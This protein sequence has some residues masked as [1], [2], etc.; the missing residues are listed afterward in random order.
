MNIKIFEE[1]CAVVGKD[2]VRINEPM[3]CHT[4]FRCGGNAKYFVLPTKENEIMDIISIANRENIQY[5]IV[6]NGSNL[7][8]SDEGY[9]GIVIT[10]SRNY[11]GI[12]IDGETVTVKAGTMLSQIGKACFH[13]ELTGFEFASGIP[14][15]LGGA[16]AMNAG[17]YGGEMK[18][19]VVSIRV[20]DDELKIRELTNEEAQFG[21]RSSLIQKQSYVVLEAKL[22]LEKGDK[23]LIKEQMEELA[24]KR[25]DKQ[26]LEYP[27]AGSTFK[28]PQGH[29]AGKLIQ[30]A[31]LLGY[32]V[33]GAKVSKKHGG[34]VINK[35]NAT[36]T[37]VY[38]LTQDVKKVV[39]DKFGVELE[40]EVKL[41]GKF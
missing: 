36:A 35:D 26:P 23:K 9:D 39:Y 33:G 8:V 22:K 40:L 12:E 7:L 19:I 29:F 28:R 41:I 6:G 17:A 1:L 21:Y 2:N 38:K 4:S 25:R 3:S 13:S 15:C 11:S 24:K 27:S 5:I 34:F 37:D 14:G 32:S 10:L 31:G 16:I 20:I 30:D 18:D